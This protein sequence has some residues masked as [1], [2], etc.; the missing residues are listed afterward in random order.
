MTFVV[1]EQQQRACSRCSPAG[2]RANGTLTYTPAA[3]R[4][5]QRPPSPCRSTDDGGTANG[6]VDTSDDPDLHDHGQPRSTTSPSFTKGADQ[7]VNED[8]G[9]QTVA[10]WATAIS[11]GPGQRV[12]PDADASS[13]RTTT[14][15]LCSRRSPAVAADGHADLH[16]GG[17]RQRQRD[18][19]ASSLKDNGGTANGGV[20]TSATQ[21]LHDHRQRGQRRADLHQGRRPDRASRTPARRPSPAG[22]RAISAG[23]AD[24]T[25]QALTFTVDERQQ[26]AL[27]A[28]AARRRSR[29]AR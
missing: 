22:R 15:A 21:T 9:A 20:D 4:Q 7:T 18:G 10:G 17:Q 1:D 16:A 2:Q 19:H 27:F 3:E 13:S 25:R 8:A 28:V 26:R 14:T 11:A 29:R 24:E 12:R 23:P 5:R 6:G